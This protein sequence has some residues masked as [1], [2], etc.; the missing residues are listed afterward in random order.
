MYGGCKDMGYVSAY[1]ID[2]DIKREFSIPEINEC[3]ICHYAIKPIDM[4][5]SYVCKGEETAA[6]ECD[7]YTTFLC[8]KCRNVFLGKFEYTLGSLQSDFPYYTGSYTLTPKTPSQ[9]QFS[10][11]IKEISPVFVEIYGQAQQAEAADLS[12]LCGVGYRK[13]LEYLVKDYLCHKYPT[14]EETIKAETLGRSI[15]RIDDGRIQAL[16]QRA[17]WIGN[18]ETHYVRRHDDLNVETMKTF[19]NAMIHFIDSELAFEQALGIDPA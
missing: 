16:A 19:I 10:E 15:Q 2:T 14:V 3:P 8:P 1:D 9:K 5:S 13:A 12:H 11:E 17:T 18:D 6:S 7:L 4:D